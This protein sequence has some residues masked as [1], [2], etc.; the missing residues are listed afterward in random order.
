M[1]VSILLGG[2]YYFFGTQDPKISITNN[3]VP[4]VVTE[5]PSRSEE[6]ER[7]SENADQQPGANNQSLG[8][9]VQQETIDDTS[10]RVFPLEGSVSENQPVA[11]NQQRVG[12]LNI[13]DRL[14][15]SGFSVSQ[16]GRTI[17]TIVLHSSYDLNGADP[18]SVSGIVK[19]YTDYGV[20]AHYLIDRKGV[21]YRL[22]RDKDIAYHA[23]VSKM[24]DGRKNVNGFSL[25][26]EMMNTEQG[27][28][29]SAQYVAVNNLIALLK[30]QYPIKYVVGHADIAPDRKTDPWNFNWK[31]VQ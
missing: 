26:I 1:I 30:K 2:G 23:G 18:Y 12:A 31:K 4:P 17:D 19:E 22:V 11:Q 7:R 21:I 24:P 13:V 9:S 25:G 14:M 15:T 29:T 3:I 8:E 16:Q 28:F 6:T 10:A 20:S 27:Q 5:E